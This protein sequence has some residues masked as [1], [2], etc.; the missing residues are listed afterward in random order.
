MHPTHSGMPTENTRRKWTHDISPDKQETILCL[1]KK[2]AT[3]PAQAEEKS[4]AFENAV[5]TAGEHHNMKS[6]A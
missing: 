1:G 2:T 6:R 3:W 4:P 5:L